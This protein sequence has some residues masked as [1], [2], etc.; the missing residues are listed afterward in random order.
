MLEFIFIVYFL[1]LFVFP[2]QIVALT[3]G[4]L[5]TWMA[6]QRIQLAIHQPHEGRKI[7]R[8]KSITATLNFCLS[9]IVSLAMAFMIHTLIFTHWYLFIFNLVFSLVI[10]LRWFDFTHLIYRHYILKFGANFKG[11]SSAFVEITGFVVRPGAILGKIPL[12]IDA[13]GLR[14]ENSVLT[15]DGVFYKQKFSPANIIQVE[16]K[17]LDRIRMVVKKNHDSEPDICL[18]GFKE[19]FY[20]FKSREK[21]DTLYQDI[22]DA[23]NKPAMRGYPIRESESG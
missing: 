16:K 9:V 21:R 13:G 4:L 17:S 8:L 14:W 22:T 7:L 10:S 23:W 2:L 18:I 3:L 12:M 6:F 5:T 15:F 20:P 1:L 11:D 19:Q